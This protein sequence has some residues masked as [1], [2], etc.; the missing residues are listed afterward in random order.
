[1]MIEILYGVSILM[2]NHGAST[3]EQRVSPIDRPIPVLCH[4][5]QTC[6]VVSL[7]FTNINSEL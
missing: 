6:Y 7:K 4:L 3:S 5:S 2:S 1:M